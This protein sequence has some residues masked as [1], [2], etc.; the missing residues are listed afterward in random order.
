MSLVTAATWLNLSTPVGLLT[1]R[2]SGC[3]LARR[4]P[5][6]EASGYSLR[7]PLASAFT[8]GSV[9]I[10]RRPLPAAVWEHEVRHIRQY[11][12]FG[13]MFVPLYGLAAAWSWARTGDWWSR[14]PFERRA[15]LTAGG[16]VERPLMRFG[17][18]SPGATDAG[19]ATA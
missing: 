4:G 5:Y 7:F 18:R 2:L 8:V 6:W 15:G 19:A 17:R 10:C 16:Y 14:N 11:A 13:P 9:V 3:R 12:W 1:A